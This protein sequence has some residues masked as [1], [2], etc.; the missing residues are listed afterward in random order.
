MSH[1]LAVGSTVSEKYGAFGV[2]NR[3]SKTTLSRSFFLLVSRPGVGKTS[4]L[5]SNPAALIINCDLS[6]TPTNAETD[7][8]P[9]A[10]FY[11]FIDENGETVGP[12]GKPFVFRYQH[13]RDITASLIRAAEAKAPRPETVVFDS[14]TT[15]LSMMVADARQHALK[16]DFVKDDLP[17][18][19][20]YDDMVLLCESLRAVGYGVGITAHLSDRHVPI[21]EGL[22]REEV[23]LSGMPDKLYTRIIPRVEYVFSMERRRESRM[24]ER[25]VSIGQGRTMKK[26]EA[27]QVDVVEL[28]NYSPLLWK[29]VKGRSTMPD[30]IT[31]PSK[32][33][34]AVLEAAFAQGALPSKP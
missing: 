22:V 8:P 1:T 18:A 3:I 29:L 4:L 25:E 7:G 34:W 12:D 30:R 16:T 5:Q 28:V 21:G 6:R 27:I 33:G 15:L 26:K 10:Q 32:N 24:E 20:I 9:A 13:V 11:P 17:W 23:V 14:S 19:T 2:A 31:I